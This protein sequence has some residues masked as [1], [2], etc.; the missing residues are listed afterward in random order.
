MWARYAEYLVQFKGEEYCDQV[1]GYIEQEDSPRPL[2]FQLELL[3]KVGFSNLEI[4]HKTSVFAA[5]GAFK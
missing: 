2:M 3:R 5:F 4:L 1:F